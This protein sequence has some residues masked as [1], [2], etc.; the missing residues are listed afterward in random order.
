MA[1]LQRAHRRHFQRHPLQLA[2]AVLGITLGVA[3][4]TAV[5][6]AIESSRRA[7][8]LSM[9]ALTGKTTHHIVAG[10]GALNEALYP[11]LRQEAGDWILAPVVEGFVEA[12]GETLRLVGFDPFAD[13]PVRQ[14][15]A[16]ASLGASLDLLTQPDTVLISRLSAER[17]GVVPGT[18][19]TLEV[20]GRR[21]AL[22]LLGYVDPEGR[23]D[24]AVEGLLV[25]DIATA[26]EVLDRLGQLDRIDA[27]LPDDP[28]QIERLRRRLPEGV[29]LVDAAGRATATARMTHAFEI[30]LRAMSLLALLVGA[31][32]IY[33]AMGFAVLQRRSLL[34]DLR[35]LGVT[36]RELLT[37]IL[38]EAAQLGLWGGLLGLVLGLAAAQFLVQRIT[39]TINDLYF[40]LTV[41]QFSIAPVALARGL[42][43]GLV[44]ALAAALPAALEAAAAQP[45][46]ALHRSVLERRARRWLPWSVALGLSLGLLGG[47]LLA[48]PS[49]GLVV[50]LA[51]LFLLLIGYALLLPMAL[52]G[53]T[54]PFARLPFP[55]LRLAVR[56]CSAALSRTGPATAALTVAVATAIGVGLMV[57]SFRVT[58]AEWLEQLL[59]ADLYVARPSEPGAAG[60]PLPEDFLTAAARLPGVTAIGA[61][62]RAF[63]EAAVGRIELLALQPA[64]PERPAFR[65]KAA[66]AAEV[67]ARFRSEDTVLVSEPFATRHGLAAGDRLLLKTPHGERALPIAGVFFDYRS[68]QGVVVMRRDLYARLWDDP[69]I[70][71][72][73]L[74]LERH[75]SLEEVRGSLSRLARDAGPFSI[76]SNREI[77]AASMEV[78]QRTFAITE[79]LRL[80]AT[81]VACAGLVGA[82]LALQ[83]ERARE[84]AVLRALGVTPRQLA[85]LV[86]AQT[87]FLGLNAGLLAMPL[88]LL[89]A[90]ALV[91]VIN[92]RSFGWTMD[93]TV[94]LPL[95]GQAPLLALVAAW[96]AGL[97]PAWR[98]A[99]ANTAKALRDE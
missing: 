89:L 83:L 45:A 73:G 28:G 58:V 50:A 14:G 22:R 43:L 77:R 76:R 47:G 95:L 27:V 99:H 52:V 90:W 15:L 71:S 59:Q 66:A 82:L 16:K 42:G 81:A 96:L 20:A 69:G 36:R 29:E 88:G 26:Q 1:L 46:L 32:I 40:V 57:E 9:D 7:F 61:S 24:P 84:F 44:V 34:A 19:L 4:W 12:N 55:L 31:F 60:R 92:L 75:E 68:D 65:F 18:T 80:I 51:G 97:Y 3:M 41:T 53:L 64:Y 33:H 56:G 30:N 62:R 10:S 23:A 78:F 5:D 37:E 74:Y 79:V 49:A 94:S 48:L 70:T 85:T 98:A 87:T 38:L 93:L 25:A 21:H 67:W 91:T 54:G 8:A 72:L 63:V 6:L 86:L 13:L 35:I 2:L 11:K 17:L 39:H